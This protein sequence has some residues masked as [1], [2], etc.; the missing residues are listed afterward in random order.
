MAIYG[1]LLTL[2]L[3]AAAVRSAEAEPAHYLVLEQD[4]AGTVRVLHHRVVELRKALRSLS[5]S[6]VAR[7]RAAVLGGAD[8]VA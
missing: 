5:T 2:V 7:R 3:A 6:E 1:L 8:V 4:P